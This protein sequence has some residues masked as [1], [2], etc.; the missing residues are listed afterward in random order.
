[1]YWFRRPPYFRWASAV[2]LVLFALWM[3]LKGPPVE[4][5]PFAI[6]DIEVG[7]KI[8]Q[9]SV[10]YREVPEGILPE[11]ATLSYAAISITAGEPLTATATTDR[12]PLPDGWW[13][14]EIPTPTGVLPGTELR[15]IDDESGTDVPALVLSLG[16][17]SESDAWSEDLSMV[18]IPADQAASVASAKSLGTL[19]VLITAW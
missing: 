4:L 7:A 16:S 6:D 13:A 18:A 9:S 5:R 19:T 15:L 12:A 11:V 1:M 10:E 14:I 3:D 8:D 2:A 17:Q